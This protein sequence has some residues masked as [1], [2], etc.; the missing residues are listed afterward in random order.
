ML[1]YIL[2]SS[3]TDAYLLVGGGGGD[4]YLF[5]AL[6][7]CRLVEAFVVLRFPFFGAN[8]IE[9]SLIIQSLHPVSP[10]HLRITSPVLHSFSDL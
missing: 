8:G 10:I 2:T 4:H 6:C 1:V 9:Y 5:V 3:S 7:T